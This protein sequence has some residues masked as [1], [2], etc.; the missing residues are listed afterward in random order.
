MTADIRWF[1]PNQYGA[2]VVP[3]L[4]ERLTVPPHREL[5]DPATTFVALDDDEALVA[6]I[7]SAI[8]RGP[9][10]TPAVGDLTID[11]AADRLAARCRALIG[12]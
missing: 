3:G 2:V 8:A 5:L 11:A 1:S 12:A 9:L 6:A 10:A 7:Q 4:R